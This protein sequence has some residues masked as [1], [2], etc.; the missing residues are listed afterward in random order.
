M[1]LPV[2]GALAVALALMFGG[3]RRDVKTASQAFQSPLETPTQPPYPPPGHRRR[4]HVAQLRL[5]LSRLSPAR[6]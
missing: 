4:Y 5:V 3:L 6:L 1:G 2:L